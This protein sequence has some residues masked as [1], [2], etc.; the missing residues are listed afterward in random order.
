MFPMVAEVAELTAAREILDVEVRRGATRGMR[1]PSLIEV[2]AMIEVPALLWQLEPL[3]EKVDFLSVGSNDLIQF[4]FACDRGN[5]RL[6]NRYDT[7]APAMLAALA[8]LVRRADEAG[9]PIG[10]C[11]E[12]AGHPVEALALVGIGFRR[13]SMVPSGIGPVKTMVRSLQLGAIREFLAGLDRLG[14]HSLRPKLRAFARDH[15]VI[16]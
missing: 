13:L 3:L 14:D 10:V 1:P 11:G 16:I 12:M 8:E 5:P 4:L 6:A 2:G 7:L 15:G 9:V